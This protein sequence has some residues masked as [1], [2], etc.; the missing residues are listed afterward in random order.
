MDKLKQQIKTHYDEVTPSQEF[1]NSLA[2]LEPPAPAHK[3]RGYLIAVAAMLALMIGG[4]CLWQQVRAPQVI[5]PAPVTMQQ[6][7][8]PA[9][10]KPAAPSETP[11]P[12]LPEEPAEV[13]PAPAE[14]KPEPEAPNQEPVCKPAAPA[15]SIPA[16]A[17]PDQPDPEIS[18]PAEPVPGE[19][20]DPVPVEPPEN[21]DPSETDDPAKTTDPDEQ[22]PR[23]DLQAT[24]EGGIVTLTNG[25]GEQ[26]TI[27]VSEQF[28]Q[29]TYYGV[30]TVFGEQIDIF[31]YPDE[32][33][34]TAVLAGYL[35]EPSQN[36]ELI[37]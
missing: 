12:K 4:A 26:A 11:A 10:G 14:P 1:L 31:L 34:E 33:S 17:E 28:R 25:A 30:F 18:E 6:P 29:R 21:D 36:K 5:E 3:N 23:A 22:L 13:R 24:Y 9:S 2:A 27:D 19:S 32:S 35:D 20:S 7:V 15:P 37:E 16:P 8:Q